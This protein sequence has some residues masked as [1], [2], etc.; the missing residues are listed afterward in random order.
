[1]LAHCPIVFNRPRFQ[2]GENIS[3]LKLPVAANPAVRS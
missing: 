3:Q 1:M 2:L